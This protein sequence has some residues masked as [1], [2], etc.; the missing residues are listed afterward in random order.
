ME[1]SVNFS[2][3]FSRNSPHVLT[4]LFVLFFLVP[5]GFGPPTLY[6]INSTAIRVSWNPPTNPNGNVILYKIYV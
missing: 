1:V 4:V 5:E 3:R 2:G 6:T